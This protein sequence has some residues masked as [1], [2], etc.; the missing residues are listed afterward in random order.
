MSSKFRAPLMHG[1]IGTEA[2]CRIKSLEGEE[3]LIGCVGAKGGRGTK[4]HGSIKVL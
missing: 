1:E 4:G 2:F 3:F